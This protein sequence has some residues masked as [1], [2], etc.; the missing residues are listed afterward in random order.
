[1]PLSETKI[2]A[3]KERKEKYAENA[4]KHPLFK[5]IAGRSPQ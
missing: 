3:R 4:E 1:M 5:G 2:I